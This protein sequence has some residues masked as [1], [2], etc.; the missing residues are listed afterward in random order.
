MKTS[1]PQP[2]ETVTIPCQALKSVMACAYFV[3]RENL[4]PA[5]IADKLKLAVKAIEDAIPKREG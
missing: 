2:T 1:K 5:D 4:V 3:I